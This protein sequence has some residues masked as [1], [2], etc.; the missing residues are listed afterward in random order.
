M[1]LGTLGV[2][3]GAFGMLLGLFLPVFAFLERSGCSWAYGVHSASV[4]GR[5]VGVSRLCWGEVRGECYNLE[6]Y[7]AACWLFRFFMF[8][9]QPIALGV[10]ISSSFLL[11]VGCFAFLLDYPSMFSAFLDCAFRSLARSGFAAQGPDFSSLGRSWALLGGLVPCWALS[12]AFG[13]SWA[14]PGRFWVG[15]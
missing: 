15:F 12:C 6:V 11:L 13:R 10:A 9:F 7:L 5:A 3:L 2:L 8:L 4:P 1:F 14:R